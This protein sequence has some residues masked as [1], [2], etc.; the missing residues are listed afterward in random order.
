MKIKGS[1]AGV[2]AL[3]LLIGCI[4]GSGC[5]GNA[6]QSNEALKDINPETP[7]SVVY[8]FDLTSNGETRTVVQDSLILIKLEENPTTGYR[9]E[10]SVNDSL[11]VLGDTYESSVQTGKLVGGG[12]TRIFELH[13]SEPGTYTFTAVYKRPMEEMRGDEDTFVLTL[14]LE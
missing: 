7:S 13:A 4:A 3:F 6:N 10:Y 9:W 5:L 1:L 8:L 2:L 11:M 14:I 12:G